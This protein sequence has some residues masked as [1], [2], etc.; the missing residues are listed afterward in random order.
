MTSRSQPN[1]NRIARIYRWA[2]YLTLGPLL[3]RTR[4]HFLPQLTHCRRALILGDG[5]GRFTA[6]L[7]ERQPK[8]HAFAVDTSA[9]MLS[10]LRQRCRHSI[11]RLQTLQA[12]ALDLFPTTKASSPPTMSSPQASSPTTINQPKAPTSLATIKYP[13][14]S[15]SGLI[16]P[17]EKEGAL[18]PDLIATHFFL[19]CLTQPEVDAL[20]Q[21]IAAQLQPG[22]LW[23]VSDFGQPHP[24]V[25][26]PFATFYI[27]ALY[28]VFR[29]LT[30]LRVTR[31]PNPQSA[32][33]N[34]NFDRIARHDLL[35]GLIYTEIWRCR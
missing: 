18:A 23:L 32:L 25:L 7:L 15:A 17:L 5:D 29:I 8:L 24:R 14:A 9:T 35:C 28:F 19:D 22:A 2:E 34:A 16:V 31:L 3:I 10:L 26:R 6:N 13:E 21:R 33:R 30:G 11:S 20:T 1:F 27:R 4:N 12:S